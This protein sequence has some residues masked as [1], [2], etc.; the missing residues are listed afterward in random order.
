LA[1]VAGLCI[2]AAPNARALEGS[3]SPYLKGFRDFATGI[4]PAPGL[5]VR[6]DLYYYSGKEKS[7]IPQGD[8]STSVH[9]YAN[10]LNLTAVTPYRI[11]GSNYAF[12]IR[13]AATYVDAD[14]SLTTKVR[15]ITRSGEL[16]ALNDM[17][18][19]PLIVGWHAGNFHWNFVTTVW[20]PV[21][22]YDSARLVNTGKNYWA[23]SPQIGVTYLDR[24]TGWE[25]SGAASYVFNFENHQTHYRSG[26][27]LHLDFTLGKHITPAITLGVAG[28]I[29]E[30]ITDDGGSGDTLGARKAEVFGIGPAARFRM[31][32][33]ETPVT[34][35]AK[36]YR[37]FSARNTTQGDAATLSMRVKF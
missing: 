8:L 15:T 16:T 17:V 26:D 7:Q 20:L 12:A 28:Y 23:W 18:V 30:Q 3:Q 31:K 10:L 32:A 14:R 21:G 19:N 6:N 5:Y 35:V 13:G 11:F 4:L 37:E 2:G 33:G 27:V 29:M 9:G 34:F 22:N 36:Y 25:L 1:A 24:Q